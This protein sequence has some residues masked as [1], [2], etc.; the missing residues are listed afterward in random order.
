LYGL[1]PTAMAPIIAAIAKVDNNPDNSLISC[2]EFMLPFD[3]TS[4]RINSPSQTCGFKFATPI[5][6]IIIK[7]VKIA[8]PA[9]IGMKNSPA[10]FP[11]S[12]R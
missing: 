4:L 12:F 3:P 2:F 7:T 6:G 5:S 11:D 10:T 9:I 1:I 8:K